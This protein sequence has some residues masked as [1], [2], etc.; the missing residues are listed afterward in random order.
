METY[1]FLLIL[2]L[3]VPNVDIEIKRS[4]LPLSNQK[5]VNTLPINTT[6]NKENFT[7]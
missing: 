6:E 5:G 2:K 1:C 3:K 7:K 4:G